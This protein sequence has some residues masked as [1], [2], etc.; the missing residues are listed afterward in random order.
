MQYQIGIRYKHLWAQS[1]FHF[2]ESESL[3]RIELGKEPISDPC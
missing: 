2:G 1:H 3:A